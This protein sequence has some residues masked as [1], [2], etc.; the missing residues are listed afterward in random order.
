MT[1]DAS[2]KRTLLSGYRFV[3]VTAT[4][5]MIA[6]LLCPECHQPLLELEETGAG[7]EPPVRG[8]VAH[9]RL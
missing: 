4:K 1:S 6:W 2:D 7:R 5:E 3:N 9:R 8:K